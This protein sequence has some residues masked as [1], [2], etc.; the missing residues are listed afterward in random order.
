[1]PHRVEQHLAGREHVAQR[2]LL[3]AVANVPARGARG[4]G[5]GAARRSNFKRAAAPA[6]CTAQGGVALQARRVGLLQ[7]M[8]RN[9]WARPVNLAGPTVVWR[10]QTGSRARPQPQVR[11]HGSLLCLKLAQAPAVPKARDGAAGA[12]CSPAQV[13]LARRATAAV[14]NGALD[15][16]RRL[17]HRQHVQQRALRPA[18]SR[19]APQEAVGVQPGAPPVP[20]T[21]TGAKSDAPRRAGRSTRRA[22]GRLQGGSLVQPGAP[23]APCRCRSGPSARTAPERKRVHAYNCRRQWGASCRTGPGICGCRGRQATVWVRQRALAE[24]TRHVSWPAARRPETVNR[25]CT[26]SPLAAPLHD[27]RRQSVLW[28]LATV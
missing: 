21:P 11:A 22:C 12:C 28:S 5:G 27:G 19:Q 10:V 20:P 16:P 2:V 24:L 7:G 1:M 6:L 23:H 3:L 18:A 26:W 17:A 8:A 9:R 25:S 15:L 13:G 4:G 14:G